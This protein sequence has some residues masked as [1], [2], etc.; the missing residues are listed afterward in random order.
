MVAPYSAPRVL[1]RVAYEKY[2]L[3]DLFVKKFSKK[4]KMKKLPWNKT[5]IGP[6]WMG[7]TE[8]VFGGIG[9]RNPCFGGSELE[10]PAFSA[11]KPIPRAK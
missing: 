9:V 4:I 11:T 8:L 1:S 3:K 6:Q 5:Y 2:F 10:P 7:L